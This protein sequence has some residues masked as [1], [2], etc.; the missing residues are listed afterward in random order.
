MPRY[1]LHSHSTYSDGLLTPAAVVAARGRARRRRA[2][3]DRPRRHRRPGRSAPRPHAR[4]RHHARSRRRAVGELGNAH[5]FTS[6]ALQIDPANRVLDAGLATIR[7]GRDA[8]A[9]RIAE[10]LAEAGIPGAY[11]GARKF[12]TSERL[13]SRS[14]FARFL[15]DAGYAQRNQGRVQALPDARA[16][17]AT[18]SMRGRRCPRRSSGSTPPA[19]RRSSRIRDAIGS[20]RPACAACSANSATPAATASKCSRRRT[21]RAQFAEY[22]RYARVVRAARVHRLRLSRTRRELRST[23]ATC[24]P[25]PAG[26][27]ARVV[28]L[29]ATCRIRDD[30]ERRTVFFLSDRTGIT[31]EMLG[32][33]LLTQFEEFTFQRVTIPFVDSPERVAEADPAGQRHGGRAKAGGRSSS[34]RWSTRR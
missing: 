18:S 20:R 3:A 12:V 24:P 29:V 22:A 31:A 26:V 30:A 23:W 4:R 7:S 14:H 1:D 16:S 28:A 32:N 10:S 27:D 6:S 11:E 19:V 21:R 8:R 17:R 2:R 34:A 13:I 9:H 25:L 15:V 33:S 5:A